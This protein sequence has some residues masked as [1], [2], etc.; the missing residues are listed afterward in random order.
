MDDRYTETVGNVM[1]DQI[2]HETWGVCYYE[3]PMTELRKPGGKAEVVSCEES[4]FRGSRVTG[5]DKI[6]KLGG[7]YSLVF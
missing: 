3:S 5:V 4:E 6:R 2:Y 1:V 7:D